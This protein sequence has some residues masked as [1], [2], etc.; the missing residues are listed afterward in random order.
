MRK[1]VKLFFIGVIFFCFLMAETKELRAW[2]SLSGMTCFSLQDMR[3]HFYSPLESIQNSQ[4]SQTSIEF[5]TLFRGQNRSNNTGN[6]FGIWGDIYGF[7]GR[8]RPKDTLFEKIENSDLGMQVGIDLPSQGMA[9]CLYY[10]YGSPR[11]YVARASDSLY[12]DSKFDAINHLFGLRLSKQ[13]GPMYMLVNGNFGYDQYTVST[14]NIN[15]DPY[16]G[17]GWQT[18]LYGEGEFAIPIQK[19]TLKPSVALDYRF[20][21]HND[22]KNDQGIFSGDQTYNALHSILGAR[23]YYTILDQMLD[24]QIRTHWVHQFLKESPIYALRFDSVSDMTTSTQLFFDGHPGRDWF[25]CGTG[26]QWKLGKLL[27]A[28]VDYDMLLNRYTTTHIGSVTL[29]LSF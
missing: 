18:G 17:D 20:L 2:E 10:S 13:L 3:Y 23:T 4:I 5:E 16:N 15:T 11:H 6:H 19:W 25:W 27:N 22:I 1:I 28:F 12:D 8:I 14:P 29:I 26:L 21:Q 24:V 7:S 9:K